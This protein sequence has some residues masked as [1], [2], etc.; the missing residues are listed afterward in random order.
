MSIK[1]LVYAVLISLPLVG[2]NMSAPNG[3][4]QKI[5][6]VLD[7]PQHVALLH[8]QLD[9]LVKTRLNTPATDADQ[10]ADIDNLIT[11]VKS[12]LSALEPHEVEHNVSPIPDPRPP[13]DSFRVR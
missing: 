5:N 1:N 2:C 8:W 13:V 11:D 12:E 3:S 10:I 9:D 6:P 4:S 7:K